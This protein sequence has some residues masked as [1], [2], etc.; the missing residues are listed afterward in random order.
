M[1][2]ID[3]DDFVAGAREKR[4]SAVTVGVFDGVHLGHR[5]LISRVTASGLRSIVVTFRT[6]PRHVLFP[7]RGTR[8]I[9]SLDEKVAVM[10]ALGVDVL[11]LVDFTPEFAD[12]SG[13]AFIRALYRAAAMRSLVIGHDFTCGAG[14]RFKPDDIAALCATLGVACDVVP[15]VLDAGRPVSSSRIR[16]ALA[17]GNHAEAARLLGRPL[18]TR[19]TVLR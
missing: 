15:A 12:M 17:A 4:D 8:D 11:V 6:N 19:E 13:A 10:A 2:I 3:W 7:H 18:L 5:A 14:G 16:A 1:I 9:I